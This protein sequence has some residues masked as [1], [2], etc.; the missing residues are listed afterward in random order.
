MY[1]RVGEALQRY[2]SGKL[3]KALKV[4]PTLKNWEEILECTNYE[5]WSHNATLQATRIFV[6]NLDPERSTM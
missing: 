3:P 2:K 5:E 6:S 1:R 4:I